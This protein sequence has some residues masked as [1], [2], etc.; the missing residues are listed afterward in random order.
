MDDVITLKQL[1]EAL[2][3]IEEDT[4]EDAH[5]VWVMTHRLIIAFRHGDRFIL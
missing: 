4:Y 5:L 3:L 2:Q 1:D